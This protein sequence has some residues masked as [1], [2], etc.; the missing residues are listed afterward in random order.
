MDVKRKSTE[1]VSISG[2]FPGDRR[3]EDDGDEALTSGVPLVKLIKR[4]LIAS[5]ELVMLGAR[6][7]VAAERFRRLKARLINEHADNLGV[8]VVTSATAGDGKS[9]VAINTALAFAADMK[10]EVLLI[11]ADLRR[12]GIARWLEPTPKFGFSEILGGKTELEHALIELENAPLKILPAGSPTR[13]PVELLSSER[14]DRLFVELR[15][16]FKYVI[17]DTPPIVPFTDADVLGRLSDGILMVARNDITLQSMFRR[18]VESVTSTDVL[19]L[20]LNDATFN[21]SDRGHYHR[22]AGNYQD[23]STK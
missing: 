21:L 13:D 22:Q 15:R 12:S 2:K 14:A 10:G 23:R 19:G 1:P 11:D 18:A 4:N 8:M 20:I 7:S 3:F 5:P 16:R 17:V 6:H 9:L